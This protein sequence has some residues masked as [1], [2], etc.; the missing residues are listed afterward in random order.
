MSIKVPILFILLLAQIIASVAAEPIDIEAAVYEITSE[1]NTSDILDEES[2]I[3]VL[4][5]DKAHADSDQFL[6]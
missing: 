4:Y 6:Q 1:D 2:M 5:E 3:F